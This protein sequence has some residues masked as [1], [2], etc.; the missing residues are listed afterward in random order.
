MASSTSYYSYTD[1]H[2]VEVIV[3]RFADV[4]EQYREQAKHIDLSKPAITLPASPSQNS[5]LQTALVDAMG[6][7]GKGTLLHVPSFIIGAGT[8]LALGL[9]AMLAFRRANRFLALV[10]S[11]VVVA[12]LGLGYMTYVRRQAGLPGPA[13]ATPATLLDDARAAAG[14]LNKRQVEQEQALDEVDKQ[15]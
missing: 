1:I 3:Q 12:A 13:L 11:A 9:V 10:A 15:R 5:T 2:G 8:A 4:P 14:A 7:C 6:A